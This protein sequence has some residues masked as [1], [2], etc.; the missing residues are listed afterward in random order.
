MSV[1]H[2]KTGS[3]R[4]TST[5]VAGVALIDSFVKLHAFTLKQDL[6]KRYYIY[7]DGKI[8]ND[9]LLYPEGISEKNRSKL[10]GNCACLQNFH[11]TKLGEIT[12]FYALFNS[13][14][15]NQFQ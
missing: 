10:Y 12:V 5:N 2:L 1:L 15:L 9:V 3:P 11:T 4:I 13:S 14:Y 8:L 7:S 6:W